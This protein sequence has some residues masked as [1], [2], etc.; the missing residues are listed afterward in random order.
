MNKAMLMGRLGRDPELKTTQ[1]GG[2]VVSFSMATNEREK[3]GDQWVDATEWHYVV[4]FGRTAEL[5]AER[6]RKG[7][8]VLVD[9]KMKTRKW[10]GKD[11]VEKQRT[12]VLASTVQFLA[13]LGAGEAGAGPTE[14]QGSAARGRGHHDA[15]GGTPF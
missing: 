2:S 6:C 14:P 9:G 8:P 12:E 4:A 11:G 10:T 5:I 13:R 7:D 1:A 15:D 3:Q